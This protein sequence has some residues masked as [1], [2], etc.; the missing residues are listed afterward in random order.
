MVETEKKYR[1][2]IEQ[3]ER[4][5]ARLNEIGATFHGED[6]E[7]NT[8]FRGGILSLKPCVLRL[9]RTDGKSTLTFKQ[10]LPSETTVKHQIEHETVIEN[11]DAMNE[12][13]KNLGY[14]P[15]LIYEK[16]R[17]T[18]RINDVEIVLDELPFGL[19]MEIEGDEAKIL[20]TEKLLS[21]N[22]LQTENETYPSLTYKHGAKNG[23]LIESR[24]V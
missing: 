10:R 7:E 24:F 17:K 14:F 20:E 21:I 2:T 15:S 16:R 13:I 23:N 1:L 4:V 19:F 22:D 18:W 8:L 9:R 6:F 12:I 11:A 3:R 5:S